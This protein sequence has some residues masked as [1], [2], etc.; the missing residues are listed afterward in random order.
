MR[1]ID[2]ALK[3]LRQIVRDRKS[4]LFLVLI[5][6]IFT[7]FIGLV[8]VASGGEVRLPIGWLNHDEGGALSTQLR[9]RLEEAEAIRL[10]VVEEKDAGQLDTRVRDEELIAAVIVP[11]EF[12]ARTMTG[13]TIP[14]TLSVPGTPAGQTAT[15]AV[16][17]IV[18]RLLGSVQTAQLSAQA[19]EAKT[20]F[21]DEAARKAYTDE[22]LSLATQA[23]QQTPLTIKSEAATGAMAKAQTA[24]G[25]VQASPGMIVQFAV[26]SLITSA[27]VL[28]LERQSKTLERLLT[29]PISRAEI[30][31]GH[32]LA[33]FVVGFVQQV[34]L[35]ALGQFA[36]HVDYLREP[37]GTLLMMA[38]LSLW[39][40]CLGLFI[41]AIAKGAE[42]VVMFALVAMFVFAAMGGAWF[43]L[44]VA[45]KTFASI[46][47]LMP[48]AWAMDGFQNIVMRGQGLSS[49]LVPA[50]ILLIYAVA[51]FGLAAWRFRFE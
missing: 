10:V 30:I 50:G 6:I 29:T 43:P 14:L 2:L 49:V 4:A 41:S 21:A 32:V 22:A 13:E 20:P 35:V 8:F 48:T 36:F 18:K 42:Q 44:E 39:A 47:H 38:S 15:T 1:V 34:M 5:P 33:M 19:F 37:I 46:G 3:D 45:G 31:G 24:S 28:V 17:S 26:F 27:T 23:W 11:A 51:F 40:A 7:L 25:F 12:S 9:S 16:Q